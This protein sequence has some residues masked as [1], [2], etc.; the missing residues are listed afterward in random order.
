MVELEDQTNSDVAYGVFTEANQ[1]KSKLYNR[2]CTK[3]SEKLKDLGTHRTSECQASQS[4]DGKLP[5]SRQTGD[6]P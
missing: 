6:K 1:H 2:V 5:T 3:R 4:V